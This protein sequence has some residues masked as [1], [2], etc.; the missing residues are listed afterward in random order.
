VPIILV[1]FFT[2]GACNWIITSNTPNVMR[3]RVL[4]EYVV[5]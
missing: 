2:C 5:L 3:I 1:H 4:M